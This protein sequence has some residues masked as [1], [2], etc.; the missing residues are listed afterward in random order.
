[1]TAAAALSRPRS[2]VSSETPRPSAC[3]SPTAAERS[4]RFAFEDEG[5]RLSLS[6]TPH[7]LP[8]SSQ[9]NSPS[10]APPC[11]PS[12]PSSPSS[13]FSP[14]ILLP[15]RRQKAEDAPCEE[16]GENGVSEASPNER[17][18][19]PSETERT[20]ASDLVRD[21][22]FETGSA[23]GLYMLASLAV[24]A[25]TALTRQFGG[26]STRR[27][28]ETAKRQQLF[29]LLGLPLPSPPSSPRALRQHHSSPR[30]PSFSASSSPF[31]PLPLP[32]PLART[33]K[34]SDIPQP[35]SLPSFSCS[36]SSSLPFSSLSNT[37][38][39]VAS[40]V[41]G[42]REAEKSAFPNSRFLSS[43]Q[44]PE[45]P[46]CHLTIGSCPL[47]RCGDA[48]DQQGGCCACSPHSPVLTRPLPHLPFPSLK[49]KERFFA[50]PGSQ[51]ALLYEGW[52]M[53]ESKWRRVW[54]PRYLI[55]FAVSKGPC[56]AVHRPEGRSRKRSL[57]SLQEQSL[58]S[59]YF[60][61]S[62]WSSVWASAASRNQVPVSV[63]QPSNLSSHMLLPCQKKGDRREEEQASCNSG[64]R[65]SMPLCCPETRGQDA[66][67]DGT[68][69]QGLL[70]PLFSGGKRAQEG[71]N[72]EP[73]CLGAFS[74][75]FGDAGEKK[76]PFPWKKW[77]ERRQSSAEEDGES[78]NRSGKQEADA[79]DESGRVCECCARV[80]L[81]LAAYEVNPRCAK[82][83]K[84]ETGESAPG[85]LTASSLL[86]RTGCTDTRQGGPR[87]SA[88]H[89][90]DEETKAL[91]NLLGPE[92]P[93]PTEIIPLSLEAPVQIVPA[94]LRRSNVHAPRL[95]SEQDS[96][97][98]ISSLSPSPSV[99][100]PSSPLAMS[101]RFLSCQRER[102]DGGAVSLRGEGDDLFQET[103]VFSR[104]WGGDEEQDENWECLEET[105]RGD[106]QVDRIACETLLLRG[107]GTDRLLRLASCSLLAKTVHH[108]FPS[109]R[110]R[111]LSSA[112]S[113]SRSPSPR[114]QLHASAFSSCPSTQQ[115][116]R[117]R[118]NGSDTTAPPSR[119][120][121]CA[122]SSS[123][124]SR[125][126]SLFFSSLARGK[127]SSVSSSCHCSPRTVGS[128]DSTGSLR[129]VP[130]AP[131]SRPGP[132][133]SDARAGCSVYTPRAAGGQQRGRGEWTEEG[134]SAFLSPSLRPQN[135]TET[136]DGLGER[137]RGGNAEGE[138]EMEEGKADAEKGEGAIE[139][140]E[141][142]RGRGEEGETGGE[143]N[144]E[145]PGQRV[146]RLD[147]MWAGDKR[148]TVKTTEKR[149]MEEEREWQS[150]E[151]R[152]FSFSQ[153]EEENRRFLFRDFQGAKEGD[154][155]EDT[156]ERC[157][158]S[159][160]EEA[161]SRELRMWAE[162]INLFLWPPCRSSSYQLSSSCSLCSSLYFPHQGDQAS[163]PPLESQNYCGALARQ[164]QVPRG[165]LKTQKCL[166]PFLT[167]HP[168]PDAFLPSSSPLQLFLSPCR[169]A[170][171]SSASTGDAYPHLVSSKA[172]LGVDLPWDG[173]GAFSGVHTASRCC[174]FV[175]CCG[176]RGTVCCC[177]RREKRSRERAERSLEEARSLHRNREGGNDLFTPRSGSA[178]SVGIDCLHPTRGRNGACGADSGLAGGI[179][180]EDVKGTVRQFATGQRKQRR[181]GR[182]VQVNTETTNEDEERGDKRLRRTGQQHSSVALLSEA[183]RPLPLAHR[184]L[185]AVGREKHGLLPVF[186][187]GGPEHVAQQPVCAESR[188]YSSPVGSARHHWQSREALLLC[189]LQAERRAG[190]QRAHASHS[191]SCSFRGLVKS[192]AGG[193]LNQLREQ[194]ALGPSDEGE[195]LPA[196]ASQP[197]L[198]LPGGASNPNAKGPWRAA[199]SHETADDNW[200]KWWCDRIGF[201]D[202][203]LRLFTYAVANKGSL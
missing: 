200:V 50:R 22:E 124:P 104:P 113:S 2:S 132:R 145:V 169:F 122:S 187:R 198:P 128:S 14:E 159:C 10:S 170:A 11:S 168:R 67:A 32:W 3:T 183:G 136:R 46:V 99:D 94:V 155:L 179:G 41:E 64:E 167:P 19:L 143:A 58:P 139:I 138:E 184:W 148:A 49:E 152:T 45:A 92:G 51:V 34:H 71:R 86:T 199:A 158:S 147:R 81:F 40:S 118:S 5:D 121:S 131:S 175:A 79:K 4:G 191:V 55:L 106:S 47:S 18:A 9:G 163:F 33:D 185:Q 164:T 88:S 75:L 203:R 87:S 69:L 178:P 28:C 97:C 120:S 105:E 154:F 103:P 161:G 151:C 142:E 68:L 65:S 202:L 12:C 171:L 112:S 135:S 109:R 59:P 111:S 141:E 16:S 30:S 153:P 90:D 78:M 165:L 29:T 73:A 108:C 123:A 56:E 107:V 83:R 130:A 66:S 60:H 21:G 192:P 7:T 196:S 61:S 188:S 85:S 134:A 127:I 93:S 95:S 44:P 43:L 133:A 91:V 70:S 35:A 146:L 173:R 26:E 39:A 150:G 24:A 114:R 194:L 156:H 125:S 177:A 116:P 77:R 140:E 98:S 174:S 110:I 54:R 126:P 172:F 189:L 25:A 96:S 162:A 137:Q 62:P 13:L 63:G 193:Y 157:S 180:R 201:D 23:W 190:Q 82:N 160:C 117:F 20:H 84:S 149:E 129:G 182:A 52:L 72:E 197:L 15:H 80:Q 37:C 176:T 48:R 42:Q 100:D 27:R 144:G 6:E 74:S 181:E 186:S 8:P 57:S 76:R 119:F 115:F 38:Q 101:L 89:T 102:E 166:L 17:L 36:S 31:P 53:K 1:M 195:T